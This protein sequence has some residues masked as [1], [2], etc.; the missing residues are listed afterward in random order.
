MNKLEKLKNIG[1]VIASQLNE[2]GIYTKEELE[3]VGSEEAWLRIFE[4]DPSSC[5]NKLRALEGALQDVNKK[6]LTPKENEQ[7]KDFYKNYRTLK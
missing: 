7:L 3:S 2:V 5:L 1:P 4:I 6:D